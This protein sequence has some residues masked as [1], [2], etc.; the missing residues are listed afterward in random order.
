MSEVDGN[1]WTART[2][3]LLILVLGF[4]GLVCTTIHVLITM[5]VLGY[6]H[7]HASHELKRFL[8]C[9]VGIFLSVLLFAGLLCALPGPSPGKTE[10][11]KKA[12]RN[13]NVLGA[14]D[15][16]LFLTMM[17]L[18]WTS[19]TR[20][21]LSYEMKVLLYCSV[22]ISFCVIFLEV[23][24]QN[25]PK[26][27]DKILG[28]ECSDDNNN[29]VTSR[30]LWV[31]IGGLDLCIALYEPIRDWKCL[32]MVDIVLIVLTIYLV[33]A[34]SY[35]ANTKHAAVVLV[36]HSIV[37]VVILINHKVLLPELV[38]IVI[39]HPQLVSAALPALAGFV[40]WVYSFFSMKATKVEGDGGYESLASTL[41]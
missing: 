10:R 6:N 40:F 8:L 11:K 18:T 27:W 12:K 36:F 17:I 33:L 28:A 23:L 41:V 5:I 32:L 20:Y 16:F 31:L 24:L 1:K 21:G 13:D 9:F 3:T 26:E 35:R 30:L 19:S 15:C 4:V 37:T 29:N 14:A 38:R 39:N 7:G 22:E 34:D 2:F 25:N